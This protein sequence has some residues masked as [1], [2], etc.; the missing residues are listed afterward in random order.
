M[1]VK[2]YREHKYVS[3]ALN[4]LER[5]IAKADFRVEEQVQQLKLDWENTLAMLLGHAKYE[6]ERLHPLLVKKVRRNI[7]M[8]TI[9]MKRWN[10]LF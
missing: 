1:R 9:N 4:T 5:A 10:L 2:F 7:S 8:H 3:A 6:E